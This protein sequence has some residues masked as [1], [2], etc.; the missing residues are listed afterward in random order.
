MDV[1]GNISASREELIFWCAPTGNQHS[2][3]NW[4][5]VTSGVTTGV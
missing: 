2:K 4:A 3:S 5:Y 1:N